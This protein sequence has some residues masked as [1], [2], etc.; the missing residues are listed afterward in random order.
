[1]NSNHN[2][3]DVDFF[4]NKIIKS[5]DLLNHQ[6]EFILGKFIS[7]QNNF[8]WI[9]NCIEKY[10]LSYGFNYLVKNP[11][12]KK[13]EIK[14]LYLEKINKGFTI[15]KHF[16]YNDIIYKIINSE[17][18]SIILMRSL[19]MNITNKLFE[20][21]DNENIESLFNNRWFLIDDIDLWKKLPQIVRY[22]LCKN[23]GNAFL[24]YET[25]N[26]EI[27]TKF[28]KNMISEH[29][30]HGS[31]FT[32]KEFSEI[33]V[34]HPYLW[35]NKD[36]H[37]NKFEKILLMYKNKFF[38]HTKETLELCTKKS[39]IPLTHIQSLFINNVKTDFM[40]LRNS[41]K[42]EFKPLLA[43]NVNNISVKKLIL[44]GFFSNCELSKSIIQD[45]FMIIKN[46]TTGELI[47]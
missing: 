6:K 21:L 5:N 35:K 7:T 37:I 14:R 42:D 38:E 43:Q 19:Y 8:E 22:N 18:R 45:W 36:I 46:K 31:I 47:N 10:D 4:F 39:N 28:M 16:D 24:Y 40:K 33:L 13:N 23:S 2:F 44:D 20:F 29:L 1:L 27:K 11:F 9:Y 41:I 32:K 26:R 12:L 30:K 3:P 15:L 25:Q 34:N 17:M